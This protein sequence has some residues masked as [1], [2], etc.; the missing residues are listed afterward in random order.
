M[1]GADWCGWTLKQI[2]ELGGKD[3]IADLYINCDLNTD[4][5]D[6]KKIEGMPAWVNENGDNYAGYLSIDKIKTS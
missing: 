3:S 2:E 6:K 5:C 1:Y 4:I